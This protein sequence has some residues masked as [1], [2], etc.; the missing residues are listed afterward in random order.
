M[1]CSLPPALTDEQLFAAL[2]ETADPAVLAHL[3]GCPSCAARLERARKPDRDLVDRLY[4]WDCP[5][6]QQLADYYLGLAASEQAQNIEMH[7][8]QC[9][10]CAAEVAQLRRFLAAAGLPA[11]LAQAVPKRPI[12]AGL[13]A[14]LRPASHGGA[15]AVRGAGHSSLVAEADGLTIYLEVQPAGDAQVMLLGQLMA[16]DPDAWAG[17]L[18]ELRQAGVL[19]AT[20]ALDDMGGWMC[21]PFPAGLAELRIAGEDG[22]FVTLEQV[23]LRR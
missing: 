16:D 15:P 5:P 4:R 9:P 1:I 23:E 18:V 19:Q 8:A 7:L 6:A 10:G 17:G 11:A 22:R 2:D 20:A 13:V 12:R 3:A 21:G 14:R